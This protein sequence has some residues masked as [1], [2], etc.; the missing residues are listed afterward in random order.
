M[1]NENNKFERLDLNDRLNY[2]LDKMEDGADR[3]LFINKKSST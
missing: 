1:K 2:V 3:M